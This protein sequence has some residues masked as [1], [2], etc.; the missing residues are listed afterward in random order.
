MFQY[1]TKAITFATVIFP[2]F[3]ISSGSEKL[4]TAEG[5]SRIRTVLEAVISPDGNYIAYSLAIPRELSNQEDGASFQEL[6]VINFQSGETRAFRTGNVNISSLSWTPDSMKISFLEKRKEHPV[7]VYA[8]PVNGGES[9]LVI[10]L[11]SGIFSYSWSPD[12][13][14]IAIITNEPQD[15]K[16]KKVK[17]LGFNQEIYEEDWLLRRV[18]IFDTL[19]QK[20][21]AKPIDLPGS[22]FS[23][24]WS[25]TG[26]QLAISI[27]PKPLVDDRFTAQNI[28]IYSLES[29]QIE[30]LTT[31][32]KLGTFRWSPDGD[33]IGAIVSNDKNDP[34]AGILEIFK[35]EI[36][37]PIT[38]IQ[39]QEGH[40]RTFAWQSPSKL[41]YLLDEGVWSSL[42]EENI[43]VSEKKVL[44][45]AG[46]PVMSNLSLSNNG[47]SA[48]FVGHS[49]SHPREV[50][51]MRYGE[52]NPQKL[53][54]NNQWLSEV[55][56][57]PQEVVRHLARDNIE[58]EGILIRPLN[59]VQ[60]TRYPLVVV[61][62]GG[63]ESHIRNG[64]ISSYSS[65]G[66][67]LAAKDIAV[68]FP[69]YR[70]S[71]G[72]G[73][74]FSKLSQ[75]D[76]AGKEFDDIVDAVD[77]L[78]EEGLA[79]AEKIGVTG[80]S[81]GGYATAW[82]STYYSDRFA[83]GVMF[84]GIS[85]KLSK[86]GTTDIPEED[87]L[88]HTLKR[89]WDDWQFFLE[90]S[91]IYHTGQSKTPLLILHGQV[92]SRVNIGQSKELYRH[93]KLRSQAPVR[94]VIYQGEGHG[95]RRAASRLDYHLRALR[96][97]EHYLKG[98]Q[99]P[100]PPFTVEYPKSVLTK[101]QSK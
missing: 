80:G 92:D 38:R 65:L 32:G 23:V 62:H 13:R 96:W 77:H 85:N 83:A 76:P 64:W 1:L 63:P 97:F 11:H 82:C 73:L 90:R 35:K 10:R 49:P 54:D 94:L 17:K 59:E 71:T 8:I 41:M 21:N 81:Y 56:L 19:D 66:Q 70:G 30:T 44:I 18:W 2:F 50:F 60:R 53:T 25:P 74:E 16:N 9:Q 39:H 37:E 57:A 43:D 45:Q 99:N 22:A 33:H 5:I 55:R 29:E 67:T 69:N 3:S 79:N 15:E 36:P 34:H 47:Q 84:V 93:M 46:G 91:P 28:H 40:I 31:T 68:F 75:G 42:R 58:L 48:A 61:V 95:N 4:L 78:I 7:S 88:V 87:F 20:S 24:R 100:P 12:G 6:H 14:Q 52:F 26:K 86:F 89:P 51:S 72:R 101:E 98:S 27:A